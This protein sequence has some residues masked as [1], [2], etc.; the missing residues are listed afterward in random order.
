VDRLNRGQEPPPGTTRRGSGDHRV[1]TPPPRRRHLTG[2]GSLLALGLGLALGLRLL[3]VGIAGVLPEVLPGPF[4]V[5]RFAEIAPLAGF[6]PWLPI[7]RPESLGGRPVAIT[8]DRRPHPRVLVRWRGS[9]WLHL[10]ERRAGGAE[11]SPAAAATP[12][13][14]PFPAWTWPAGKGLRALALV[15]LAGGETLAV[16]VDSDL[17]RRELERLVASLR[18]EPELR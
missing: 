14:A 13:A 18:P 6:D 8:V 16:T 1:V 3:H 17:S 7:Y 12:L 5:E 2:L 11:V 9:H 10:E 4:A 15:P